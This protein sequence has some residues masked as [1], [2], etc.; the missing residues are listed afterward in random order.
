MMIRIE[1]SNEVLKD[2]EEVKR[3]LEKAGNILYRTPAQIKIIVEEC[4]TEIKDSQ[5]TR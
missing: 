5:D 4:D 2:L 1:G 3:L